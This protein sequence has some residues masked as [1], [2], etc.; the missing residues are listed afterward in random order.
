LLKKGKKSEMGTM[1]IFSASLIAAIWCFRYS[2]SYYEIITHTAQFVLSNKEAMVDSF[3]A[4]LRMFGIEENFSAFIVSLKTVC[5]HLISV[6]NPYF[7]LCQN[8]LV[9]YAS[10]LTLSA[11]ITGGAI[12]FEI[13][14]SVFPKIKLAFS[15]LFFWRKKYFFSHLNEASIALAHSIYDVNESIIKKPI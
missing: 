10:V 11:P 1:L 9:A 3:F 14:A 7:N 4:T 12:L 2:V 5:V 15:Y 13:L 6:D 8:L